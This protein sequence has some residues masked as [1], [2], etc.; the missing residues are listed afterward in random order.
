MEFETWWKNVGQFC[1]V[2]N[3]NLKQ[4]EELKQL[5]RFVW[6]DCNTRFEIRV[7]D[8]V[9]DAVEGMEDE[10]IMELKRLKSDIN[11]VLERY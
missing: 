11:G 7:D 8:L 6:E 4:K 10:H 1:E 9:R 2:V 5:A 3:N